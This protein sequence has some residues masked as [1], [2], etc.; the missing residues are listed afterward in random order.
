MNGRAGRY[1][2]GSDSRNSKLNEDIVEVIRRRM[3]DGE[4]V[5]ELAAEFHVSQVTITRASTGR[6]WKQVE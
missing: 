4:S 2:S 5:Q 6:D 3:A 1:E